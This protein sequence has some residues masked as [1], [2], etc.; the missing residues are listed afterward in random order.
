M[1]TTLTGNKL[2]EYLDHLHA[3]VGEHMQGK[4]GTF[5]YEMHQQMQNIL[6]AEKSFL[7]QYHKDKPMLIFSGNGF[8]TIESFRPDLEAIAGLGDSSKQ[9]KL[10]ADRYTPQFENEG[11]EEEKSMYREV[12]E[13]DWAK[14]IVDT[15][16]IN[17]VNKFNLAENEGK[18]EL[19]LVQGVYLDAIDDF[20]KKY[21]IA[22]VEGKTTYQVAWE[23]VISQTSSRFQTA[24]RDLTRSENGLAQGYN[25]E[26]LRIKGKSTGDMHKL[27]SEDWV[28]LSKYQKES[29]RLIIL[30]KLASQLAMIRK[31]A[32]FE[33]VN[34]DWCV[35]QK[36]QV[37]RIKKRLF[38]KNIEVTELKK[39]QIFSTW[40]NVDK[41]LITIYSTDSAE[42][43]EQI[44]D[45]INN[46]DA[47]R[48]L[49]IEKE[50]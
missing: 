6:G 41:P 26:N 22:M 20:S 19:R 14:S 21:P 18:L 47:R 37:P 35:Y 45:K 23:R 44:I 8:P 4:E 7:E 16:N 30:T 48:I 29:Q 34:G 1:T 36:T 25:Y 40:M 3:E 9:F 49:D 32:D 12:S 33:V 46:G 2:F 50:I 10:I 15:R 39:Q 17:V 43:I 31:D 11:T 5:E 27:I 28:N 24:I 38:R 42:L 13:L